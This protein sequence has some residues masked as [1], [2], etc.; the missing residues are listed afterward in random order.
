MGTNP[1]SLTAMRDASHND[2]SSPPRKKQAPPPLR[3][4]FAA[5]PLLLL[6]LTTGGAFWGGRILRGVASANA[7]D[8]AAPLAASLDQVAETGTSG[9]AHALSES[10]TAQ[11]ESTL[12]TVYALVKEHYVDELPPEQELTR[13]AVR[14]LLQSLND[15]NAQFYEPHQRILLENESKGI[16]AGIG[17]NLSVRAHKQNGYTDY[18]LTVVAP[19]PG[20]P[21][22]SA[23]LRAGDVITTVGGKWV[24]G[25]N[26]LLRA[27][28]IA[29]KIQTGDGASG[30]SDK[31]VRQTFDAAREKLRGGMG[32]FAAQMILRGDTDARKSAKLGAGP[33]IL[34]VE[35]GMQAPFR[36]SVVFQEIRVAS[37]TSKPMDKQIGYIKIN[38]LGADTPAAFQNALQRVPHAGGLVIDLR[39]NGGGFVNAAQAIDAALPLPEA[40]QK[41]APPFGW[42]E[43]RKHQMVPLPVPEPAK[44]VA[45]KIVVLINHGTANVSEVLASALVLRHNAALVGEKTFGDASVQTLYPLPDGSAFTLTTGQWFSGRRQSLS[46]GLTPLAPPAMVSSPDAALEYAVTLLHNKHNA[47]P[48]VRHSPTRPPKGKN[49]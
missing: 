46:Q 8:T 7:S 10:E 33:L 49:L 23:G 47:A 28:K 6:T 35:R 41:T 2:F 4:L 24:L 39:N 15:P 37:L 30:K 13:G 18:K 14:S 3:R 1:F 27:S 25:F 16:F 29:Q 26:P 45:P 21:A 12:Q 42:E 38:T 11:T 22:E 40:A 43:N 19:L 44:G 5:L 48:V 32:L 36:V 34:S 20:S 17:A 9:H 31:K